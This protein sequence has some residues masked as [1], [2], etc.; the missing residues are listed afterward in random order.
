MN[1]VL[2]AS[3]KPVNAYTGI[4]CILNSKQRGYAG[5]VQFRT[6]HAKLTGN[7]SRTSPDIMFLG[8]HIKMDPATIDSRDN[9]LGAQNHT[10]LAGIQLRQSVFDLLCSELLGGF[11]AP[12]SKHFVGMMVV[13][14]MMLMVVVMAATG[15]VFIVIVMMVLMVVTS[16]AAVLIMLMVVMLLVVMATAMLAMLMMVM[17]MVMVVSTA[18]VLLIMMM[19]VLMVVVVTA[20]AVMLLLMSQLLSLNTLTFH[21]GNQ[22]LTGQLLP[23]CSD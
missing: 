5:F 14:V 9:A 13:M 10:V 3:K 15:A 16:A 21:G 1:F 8:H 18:V 6:D 12:G 17:L 2:P 23:W 19:V 20:A 7:V 4:C 11:N 22:L